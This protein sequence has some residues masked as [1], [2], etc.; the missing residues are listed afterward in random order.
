[1]SRGRCVVAIAMALISAVP[2]GAQGVEWLNDP[3]KNLSQAVPAGGFDEARAR[4]ALQRGADINFRYS[5]YGD[6][7]VLM[8]A[9]QF[10]S[11]PEA[12]RFLLDNG[13]DPNIADGKGRTA[14]FFAAASHVNPSVAAMVQNAADR[15]A[16]ATAGAASRPALAVGA[17]AR[18]TQG[19]DADRML[20]DAMSGYYI[21]EAQARHALAAG[22]DVNQRVPNADNA[23]LLIDKVR[24]GADAS[25]IRWLLQNGANPSLRDARGRTAASYASA[26]SGPDVAALLGV[27]RPQPAHKAAPPRSTR[28]PAVNLAAPIK[29]GVYECYGQNAMIDLQTFGILDGS[30]Y[31]SSTGNIGRYSYDRRTGVLLLD[32]GADPARFQRFAENNFNA[33]NADGSS[34]AFVCPLNP[35]KDPRRPPW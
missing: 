27:G 6:Q 32:P 25:V 3:Q 13:A 30:R 31:M 24:Q 34:T 26:L 23:T 14:T 7:T 11:P 17:A 35:K 16:G 29:P 28:T 4:N 10:G 12:V 8:V 21:N 20:R 9:I 19:A 5:E 15:R 22:A 1:M 18:P 2:V 33:I